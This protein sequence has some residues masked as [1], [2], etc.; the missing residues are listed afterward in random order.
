MLARLVSNW[1]YGGALAG[2][3]LLLLAPTITHAWPVAVAT[4]FLYLPVYMLHQYE[5]HDDD[6]FRRAFNRT[7]GD[8]EALTREAVFVINVPGV[9]G[10]VGASLVLASRVGAGWSLIAAYLVLVNAAGHLAQAVRS[11]RYNPG[12]ATAA[13]LFVPLGGFSWWDVH[14][15]GDA[16]IGNDVIGLGVALAVHGAILLWVRRRL[17][18]LRRGSDDPVALLGDTVS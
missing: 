16:T 5:E 6:R 9:W 10:V 14:A 7:L 13:V 2:V 8:R 17:R 15:T 12:L 1:V 3:L 4:A 18:A 11:R